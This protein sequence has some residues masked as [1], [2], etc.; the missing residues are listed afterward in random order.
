MI[1]R[2][3]VISLIGAALDN[4]P[5]LKCVVGLDGFIDRIIRVIKS[6]NADTTIDHYV[7]IPSLAARVA[8]AA[9]RSTALELDVQR[10]KLGGNGPI[11]A[12]ALAALGSSVTYIGAVGANNEVHPVFAPLTDVCN[13]IAVSEPAETDALEFTD[14]KIMLQKM[15]CLDQLDYQQILDYI[16]VDELIELF[17]SADLVSLDNW[18]SMN[19]MSSIWE[20][21]QSHVCSQLPVNDRRYFFADLANPERRSRNEISRALHLVSEFQQWFQTILGLNLR[22]SEVIA[23]LLDCEPGPGSVTEVICNRASAIRNR[24]SINCVTIHTAQHA[25]AA[26]EVGT[27]VINTLH[28][29]TPFT[30]TGA[31]DHYNAGFCFGMLLELPCRQCLELAV[32]VSGFFV[33]ND[34]A[35]TIEKLK[36][37]LLE[38]D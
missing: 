3:D 36:N 16:G 22:E 13:V 26:D 11:M 28:T 18:S 8:G 25:A 32:G 34:E 20:N 14:G 6:R 21:L 9:G 15:T 7:D 30:L 38:T 31:G 12:N 2:P 24:L 37:F 17:K 33:R 10:T 19:N 4:R 5:P 29:A 1:S 35:P 23:E 27:S